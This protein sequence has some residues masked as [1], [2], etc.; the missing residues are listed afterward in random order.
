MLKGVHRVDD[1]I[2]SSTWQ[3]SKTLV[4]AQGL[5]TARCQGMAIGSFLQSMQ[6]RKALDSYTR[7]LISGVIED[8]ALHRSPV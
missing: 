6:M 3:L 7:I 2:R 1:A 4:I 8:G 5:P